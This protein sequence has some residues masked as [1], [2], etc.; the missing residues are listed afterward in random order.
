MG[1]LGNRVI[2]HHESVCGAAGRRPRDQPRARGAH[3]RSRRSTRPSQEGNDGASGRDFGHEGGPAGWGPADW[4]PGTNSGAALRPARAAP[5]GP[6]GPQEAPPERGVRPGRARP[7]RWA[8]GSSAPTPTSRTYTK[9]IPNS[10]RC[11]RGLRNSRRARVPLGKPPVPAAPGTRP[12]ASHLLRSTPREPAA[13]EGAGAARTTVDSHTQFIARQPSV[14]RGY[15]PCPAPLDRSVTRSRPAGGGATALTRLDG[16]RMNGARALSVWPRGRRGPDRRGGPD[17]LLR[18][19]PAASSEERGSAAVSCPAR[20]AGET[21]TMWLQP[22]G[23]GRWP[24]RGQRAAPPAGAG[25]GGRPRAAPG[26]APRL[27]GGG[28]R[29]RGGRRR[30]DGRRAPSAGCGPTWWCSTYGSPAATAWRLPV[31]PPP[32]GRPGRGRARPHRPRRRGRP[33]RRPGRGGGRLPGQ[34]L[35]AGGAAGAGAGPAAPRLAAR[36]GGAGLRRGGAGRGGAGRPARRAG[37]RPD[38]HGAPPAGTVPA[39]PGTGAQ[40]GGHRPAPL[41]A[42]LR[43]GEQHHRR[44]RAPPGRKLEAGGE[45]PLLHTVRGAGYALREAPYDPSL[46]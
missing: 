5:V 36:A 13:P 41:G 45:P 20:A 3:R 7:A 24:S 11:G 21:T 8:S 27:G 15:H 12:S 23:G 42:G 31:D 44:L 28:V 9:L 6:T 38:H 22:G 19:R 2:I 16:P 1:G 46:P 35:R 25:G 10:W 17:V 14:P 40:P 37:G 26:P 32:A 33:H 34:A 4:P 29:G 30:G 43:G 39:P 18:H